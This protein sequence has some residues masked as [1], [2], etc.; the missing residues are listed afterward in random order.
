MGVETAYSGA[1][2][3]GETILEEEKGA[4]EGERPD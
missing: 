1:A 2:F 4:D 3:V